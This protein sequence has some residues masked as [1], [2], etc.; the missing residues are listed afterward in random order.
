VSVTDPV[1]IGSA[2]EGA[3]TVTVTLSAWVLLTLFD[4]GVTVTVGVTALTVTGAVPEALP[5]MGLPVS[6]A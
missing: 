1:G 3:A 2:L 4:A 5:Y 6:G